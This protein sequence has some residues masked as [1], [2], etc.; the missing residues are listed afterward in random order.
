MVVV[1]RQTVLAQNRA[2]V[3]NNCRAE[4]Q[5]RAPESVSPV[6]SNDPDTQTHKACVLHSAQKKGRTVKHAKRATKLCNEQKNIL[7]KTAF[8]SFLVLIMG[9]DC[10]KF[11]QLRTET[12]LCLL[13]ISEHTVCCVHLHCTTHWAHTVQQT[14]HQHTNE[15]KRSQRTKN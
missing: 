12:L 5:M 3:E 14:G 11:A 13:L 2:T 15:R 9:T 8:S 4:W 1:I 6:A 10:W 7:Y